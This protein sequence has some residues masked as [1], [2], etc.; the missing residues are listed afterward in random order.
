[1]VPHFVVGYTTILICVS[2]AELQNS[3]K[4]Q[5]NA[6]VLNL[7]PKQARHQLH[8][9]LSVKASPSSAQISGIPNSK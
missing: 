5:K 7:G 2:Q 3:K 9:I 6:R 4:E 8:Y 1:M